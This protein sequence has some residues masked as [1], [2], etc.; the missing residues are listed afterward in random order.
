FSGFVVQTS[1]T[2]L[3]V[4]LVSFTGI[5][6]S[7]N[8]ALLSWN[9]EEQQS[10]REYIVERS[11]DGTHFLP[12]GNVIANNYSQ[13]IY[14]FTDHNPVSGIAFYRLKVVEDTRAEYSKTIFLKASDIGSVSVYPVP[15]GN[16]VVIQATD[17]DLINKKARLIDVSG[18]ILK[19]FII[20]NLPQTIDISNL[21]SGVYYIKIGSMGVKIIKK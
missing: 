12:A 21:R 9:V 18:K 5:L 2:I 7:D 20:K 1:L 17:T 6:N 8:R 15:A 3:P 14:N 19:E 13:Y 16:S 11:N 4:K 10:I